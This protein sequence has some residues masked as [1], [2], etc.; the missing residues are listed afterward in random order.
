MVRTAT[1]NPPAAKGKVAMIVILYVLS[2]VI[3]LL[4]AGFCVYSAINNVQMQVMPSTI[5]GLIFGMII[6]FLGIR[7][8]MSLSKLREEVMKSAGFSWSNFRKTKKSRA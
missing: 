3:M 8:F 6:L 4:G 2:V 1:A 5:P 7:Y